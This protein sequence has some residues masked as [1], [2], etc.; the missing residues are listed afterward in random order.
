MKSAAVGLISGHRYDVH[1]NV[2]KA[3]K[4]GKSQKKGVYSA[5]LLPQASPAIRMARVRSIVM[6]WYVSCHANHAGFSYR[7]VLRCAL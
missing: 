3:S 2:G 6:S 1:G 7:L 4:K 5:D